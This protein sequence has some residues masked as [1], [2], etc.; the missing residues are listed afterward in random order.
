MMSAERGGPRTIAVAT[1]IAA[2]LTL[3]LTA[4]APAF[5]SEPIESFTTTT[6]TTQ[7]GGHPTLETTFN[8]A[9]P[10]GAEIAKNVIFNAPTG[11]FGNSN[12]ITQCT[13]VYFALEECPTNSQAGLITIY[14]SYEGDPHHLMGTAPLYDLVPQTSSETA[15]FSF[16]VPILNIP[17]N[18]PVAVRT[19]SD[20]GLRF[21]VQDITQLVPLASANLTFWG[22]P[23]EGIHNAERFPKGTPGDPAGCPGLANT[24]CMGGAEASISVHPLTDNPTI[25]TGSR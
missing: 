20:Y 12:A 2:A 15:R 4:A 25:C 1:V 13:S 3:A 14:A 9:E 18:I 22:F 6:S 8:L 16:I 24:T 7:A 19:E 11:V 10:G 23:A 17:I 5:A 21:T